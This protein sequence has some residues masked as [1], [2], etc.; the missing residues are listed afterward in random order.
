MFIN[1]S[2]G[3]AA[4]LFTIVHELAHIWTGQSAGFDFQTLQP[5]SDAI[6]ILCDKVAAEF[7]VPQSAFNEKWSDN[8]SISACSRYFKVSEIVIA[9]RALDT[10]K[11]TRSQFYEFYEEYKNRE[12]VKR[13]NQSPD[14][15]FYATAKKRLSMTFATHINNAVK[16][17]QLL[18]RDAYKLTSMKGDTF[19]R[20]F[21]K[22]I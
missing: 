9:R 3:K 8:P 10:G 18:Y 19:D 17:G 12:F 22:T 11:I 15:D 4:Q 7:L 5:A 14:G 2:D 20:F 21:A 16:T 6:E 1:N 13:Q